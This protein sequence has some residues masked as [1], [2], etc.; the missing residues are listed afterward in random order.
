MSFALLPPSVDRS[1]LTKCAPR[2]PWANN[3]FENPCLSMSCATNIHLRR[4]FVVE[5]EFE[6]PLRDVFF[7]TPLSYPPRMIAIC[8]LFA[9]LMVCCI[10]ARSMEKD[11]AR[12]IYRETTPLVLCVLCFAV[13]PM[14]TCFAFLC[15]LLLGRMENHSE[16]TTKEGKHCP[17]PTLCMSVWKR[18]PPLLVCHVSCGLSFV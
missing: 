13:L 5:F 14:F 18:L 17:P 11:L 16:N 4:G 3:H 15:A 7:P 6:L 10:S 12:T 8:C 1:W 9:P 2:P